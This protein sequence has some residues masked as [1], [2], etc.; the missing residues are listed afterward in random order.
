MAQSNISAW[1]Q[2][3]LQQMA[4]ESYLDQMLSGRLLRDI[5]IDGNNDT[6]L[7][8]PDANGNLPGKTQFVDLAGVPNVSQVTGSAQAFV[9]RYQIVDHHANDATGRKRCQEPLF[10]LTA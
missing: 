1:L 5:L 8:Q 3:A 7:V 9:S 6:Q 10:V 4:A 2:F